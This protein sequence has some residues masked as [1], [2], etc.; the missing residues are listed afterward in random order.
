M[1]STSMKRRWNAAA[2]RSADFQKIWRHDPA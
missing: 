1:V 2:F